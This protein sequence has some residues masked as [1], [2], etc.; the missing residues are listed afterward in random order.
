MRLLSAVI[1]FFCIVTPSFGQ[2]TCEQQIV[3]NV[4]DSKGE[5]LSGLDTSSFHANVGGHEAVVTSAGVFAGSNRVIL[6]LDASGSMGGDRNMKRW[7]AIKTFAKQIVALAPASTELAMLIFNRKIVRKVEFGHSRK[8]LLDTIEQSSDA[9][10]MTALWTSLLE[11]SEMFSTPLPG[12]S[13][14]VVSDFVDDTHKTNVATVQS[15]FVNK[16]IRL[17][18][19]GIGSF[20]HY[21]ADAEDREGQDKFFALVKQTGGDV[22]DVGEHRDDRLLQQLFDEPGKFYVLKITPTVPVQK[23]ERLTLGLVTGTGN[24]NKG[25]TLYYP[26]RFVPCAP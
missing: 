3:V 4:R 21:L 24:K 13:V 14:L 18:G 11:A 1:F 20:D 15:A 6:V 25:I 5:F 22:I 7:H 2:S 10:G 26:Q 19:A 8:E 23:P 12:D 17:F 9:N 16:R